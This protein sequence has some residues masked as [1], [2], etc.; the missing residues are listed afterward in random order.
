MSQYPNCR[1]E[2]TNSSRYPYYS[3]RSGSIPV[4]IMTTFWRV[5]LLP[6]GLPE[7]VRQTIRRCHPADNASLRL[8]H[9]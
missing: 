5:P 1:S 2:E 9:A 3:F 8:D 4:P 7:R 6:V